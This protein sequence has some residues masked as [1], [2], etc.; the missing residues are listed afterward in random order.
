MFVERIIPPRPSQLGELPSG[1][2]G[3]VETLRLMR[4]RVRAGKTNPHIRAQALT[5]IADLPAK[6]YGREIAR[7]FEFVRDRIRYTR[8]VR[9]V[10]TLQEP[11]ITL[12][13]RVG[14]CDDK[15]TLLAALLESV[16]HPTRAVAIGLSGAPLSH[17]YL[18]TR[19]GPKWIPL[20]ATESW[21]TGIVKFKGV[22]S[23]YVQDF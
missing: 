7:I 4:S 22:T 6:Q 2:A 12:A 1:R 3:T 23:R 14:D 10:E 15:V 5:L 20:D 13:D 16:G 17:V 11:W 19:L 9:G 18:E 8:D 21:P